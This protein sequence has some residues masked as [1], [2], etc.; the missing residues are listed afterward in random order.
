MDLLKIFALS[1]LFNF[2]LSISFG[3]LVFLKN[4]KAL[5]NIIFLFLIALFNLTTG[6]YLSFIKRK[7]PG[8][9]IFIVLLFSIS[10]WSFGIFGF[11]YKVLESYKNI[12]VKITHFSGL[13]VSFIFFLFTATYTFQ[14]IKKSILFIFSLPIFLFSYQV[15]FTNNIIGNAKGLIYEIG[16]YYL[17]Y[18]FI[19]VVYFTLGF[20]NLLYK[21]L[22]QNKMRTLLL[23][24][25]GGSLL[26]VMPILLFDLIYPY[27]GKF[28][29]TW[30]GALF[31]TIWIF[32]LLVA[33]LKLN[34]YN[35]RI[36]STQFIAY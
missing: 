16:K 30:L 34:F 23:V 15:L 19:L 36:I 26:S 5:V 29:Y 8:Y 20:L 21:I 11:Y 6:L 1:G 10:L 31:V 7:E 2:I 14:N 22:T 4:R 32:A 28:E 35:I 13:L 9:L 12:W 3:I 33:I 27:L 25:F 18:T 17:F 24:I